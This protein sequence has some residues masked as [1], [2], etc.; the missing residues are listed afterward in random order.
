[1]MSTL[2]VAIFV[3]KWRRL[4]A[5]LSALMGFRQNLT[6]TMLQIARVEVLC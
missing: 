4:S 2:S 6:R 1:M 3:K 5:G